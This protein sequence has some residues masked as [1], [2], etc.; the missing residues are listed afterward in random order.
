MRILLDTTYVL[1]FVGIEVKGAASQDDVS[2][3]IRSG[4][5][6]SINQVSIFELLGKARP[7]IL[8]DEKARQRVTEG[9]KA[10]LGSGELVIYPVLDE[11]TMP[12]AMDLMADGM[13]DIP[14][15]PIA[16]SALA[17]ADMLLTEGRDIV[18]F[19]RRRRPEIRVMTLGQYLAK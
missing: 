9:L 7:L 12:F 8:R 6:I 4:N 18:E 3:L 2:G 19:L 13:R 10:I 16:A 15:V 5:G 17:Y 1:P 14:D 11:R